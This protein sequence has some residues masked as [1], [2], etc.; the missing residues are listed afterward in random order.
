MIESLG[1]HLKCSYNK[2]YSRYRSPKTILLN[3]YSCIM[4]YASRYNKLLW[5]KTAITTLSELPLINN[6]YHAGRVHKNNKKPKKGFFYLCKL[7]FQIS[8]TIFITMFACCK[9][10]GFKEVYFSYDFLRKIKLTPERNHSKCSW[11]VLFL[12]RTQFSLHYVERFL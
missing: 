4:A 9:S 12:S 5:R 2:E 7:I 1:S 6:F 10:S 3:V 8:C 11:G